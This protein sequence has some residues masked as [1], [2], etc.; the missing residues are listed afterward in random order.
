MPKVD[1]VKKLR[2]EDILI[3]PKARIQRADEK[4]SKAG[5]EDFRSS[6]TEFINRDKVE[7]RMLS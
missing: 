4:A 2:A 1:E 6:L 3:E 5:R 7:S